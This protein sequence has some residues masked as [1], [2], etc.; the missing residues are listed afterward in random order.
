MA[1]TEIPNEIK[2]MGAKKAKGEIEL[3]SYPVKPLAKTDA[4]IVITYNGVCHSDIHMI[5]NDWGMSQYPLVPGHEIVGH[6]INVGSDVTN[7]KVGD[8]VCLGCIA[9]SCLKCDVCE[10]GHDNI[11][12][13]RVFTYMGKTKDETGEHQHYGGF[14][15]FMRTDARKLFKVPEG[16][17]EKYVGPL[18]CAG[19]TVFEPIRHFLNGTEGKGKTIGIM[20]IGGLGHLAIQIAHKTGAKVVAFSRGTSKEKFAK[21][22]GADSL[23]D[24]TNEEAMKEAANTLDQ[25]IITISG[26]TYDVNPF[27][28]LMKPYGNM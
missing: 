9:Q 23:V 7:V 20:G 4:D 26:G 19:V 28:T 6:V 17:E 3:L 16:L 25:L 10:E 2:A 13:Q 22:M 18:M 8:A 14:S 21:E 1:I 24:T 12:S 5:D 11:C 15:S 27:L